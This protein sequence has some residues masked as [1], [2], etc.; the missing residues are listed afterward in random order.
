M[1]FCPACNSRV[2]TKHVIDWVREDGILS[3][4]PKVTIECQKC[5]VGISRITNND[6]TVWKEFSEIVTK[7][8]SNTSQKPIEKK[9]ESPRT[10]QKVAVKPVQNN[11]EQ[12]EDYTSYDSFDEYVNSQNSWAIIQKKT[13]TTQD[14]EFGPTVD[15]LSLD[16]RIISG[17]K[18]SGITHPYRFQVDALDAI[19]N[20]ESVVISAPTAAGKTESFLVPIIQKILDNPPKNRIFALF[21][22][23]TKAL[24][25]DQVKKI[26]EFL[27]RCNLLDKIKAMKLDGS[28]DK[29]TAEN[30]HK[31][32]PQILV[33]NFD[34]IHYNLPFASAKAKLFVEPQILVVDEA[35]SY[36]S[37]FG[38][39]VHYLI[40][41]LE[42]QMSSKPQIIAASATLDNAKEF[43][44]DL[45]ERDMRL[46]EGKGR[47]K[48]IHRYVL[49]P[50]PEIS[51]NTLMV[52][53]TAALVKNKKKT[54]VF[55][56]DVRS[57]E[58]IAKYLRSKKIRVKVHNGNLNDNDREIREKEIN[59]GF[60]DCLSCTPTLELGIDI[61]SIDGVVS[62]FTNNLENF[63][64]RIGRAGRVGQDAF[65]V[66]VLDNKDL[67]STYFRDNID[68]Y[69]SQERTCQIYKDNPIAKENN[70]WFMSRDMQGHTYEVY[71]R[72]GSY[73][74]RDIGKTISIKLSNTEYQIGKR[75]M[76]MAVYELH[77][78]A[79][80]DHDGKTYRS[81]GIFSFNSSNSYAIV[82][83]ENTNKETSP[84]VETT[85]NVLNYFQNKTLGGLQ[86][87]YCELKITQKLTG[88]YEFTQGGDERENPLNF[89]PYSDQISWSHKV[90]GVEITFPE[91]LDYETRHT[92]AHLICN[93]SC[94]VVRCE[95]HEIEGYIPDINEKTLYFYDNS[96]M[97]ANGFSRLIY[98]K[99]DRIMQ[100]ALNITN[101]CL[102]QY[103]KNGQYHGDDWGGC[104]HCTFI[105][106]YCRENN[107]LLNKQKATQI[108]SKIS[109]PNI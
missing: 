61:G 2:K 69:F 89:L 13:I 22:Y 70:E 98:E 84:H 16:S 58:L 34:T 14:P 8:T 4:K 66:L 78:N 25:T 50:R 100:Q 87:R 90:L 102:C 107:E 76:P 99:I 15:Q 49:Y 105:T 29:T 39:N 36:C 52:N 27:E 86:I 56:N 95:S 93:S 67:F 77:K 68:Q 97:G 33:T 96:A 54:L 21:I 45:F 20:N 18:K 109:T 3:Q 92:I 47:S 6:E 83:P 75:S 79:I 73:S 42:R 5:N 12:R 101:R 43:C 32:K 38:T 57:S 1:K 62:K 63:E 65:A 19:L 103:D 85:H 72:V 40:K 81:E 104:I 10:T 64:Q 46:I 37:F 74:I 17:L 35:H 80:F 9:P 82:K 60:L 28:V 31:N 91:R 44:D 30:M 23:P 71:D 11:I 94:I 53:M 7:R 41:R 51:P 88:Y 24:A 106:S 48:T 55:S 59:D 108:L 26:N